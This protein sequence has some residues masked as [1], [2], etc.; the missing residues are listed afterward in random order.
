[1][2]FCVL[3]LFPTHPIHKDCSLTYTPYVNNQCGIQKKVTISYYQQT[4]IPDNT[5]GV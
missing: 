5:S 3:F 1:M 4:L 2:S